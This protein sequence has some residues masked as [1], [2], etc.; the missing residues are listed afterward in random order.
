MRKTKKARTKV[1]M[2][3]RE[4]WMFFNPTV[5]TYQNKKMRKKRI[6]QVKTNNPIK[7]LFWGLISKITSQKSET[8]R[9]AY[10]GQASR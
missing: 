3:G 4:G 7:T 10:R 6:S 2:S 8:L 5:G 1:K 9:P